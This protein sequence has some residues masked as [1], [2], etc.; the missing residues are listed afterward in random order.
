MSTSI[1]PFPLPPIP[2]IVKMAFKITVVVG[3][4]EAAATFLVE[5]ELLLKHPEKLR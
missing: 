2:R 4:G 1:L 5:E 3:V